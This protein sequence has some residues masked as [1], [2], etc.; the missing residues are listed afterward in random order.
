MN[1]YRMFYIREGELRA[2]TFTAAH[3]E[4]AWSYAE[5]WAASF[6]DGKVLVVHFLRPLNIQLE[7]AA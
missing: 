6:E 5:R 3:S 4:A 2:I 1:L 7:L